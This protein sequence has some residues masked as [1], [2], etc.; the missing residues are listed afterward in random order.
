MR[1]ITEVK[2]YNVYRFEE[3]CEANDYEF[4]ENG[5]FYAA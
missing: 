3:H 4:L 1:E 2:T 5:K